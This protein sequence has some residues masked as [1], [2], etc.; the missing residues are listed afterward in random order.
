MNSLSVDRTARTTLR[1]HGAEDKLFGDNSTIAKLQTTVK[2]RWDFQA[3]AQQIEGP[4]EKG[5]AF[6]NWL[7]DEGR[8]A[9]QARL[10]NLA[11][12]QQEGPRSTGGE[13]APRYGRC[14]KA[15]H[16]RI[17]CRGASLPE[18]TLMG[19]ANA[20]AAELSGRRPK[21]GGGA[22]AGDTEHIS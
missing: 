2:D 4:R 14:H 1:A 13:T 12:D 10:R 19:S 3:A 17:D 11:C 21:G 8:F 18:M 6:Y 16:S 5:E 20:A 15:G 22:P 7:E 9:T